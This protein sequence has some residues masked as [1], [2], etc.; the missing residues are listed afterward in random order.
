MSEMQYQVMLAKMMAVVDVAEKV[1]NLWEL[2]P[3]TRIPDFIR[4]ALITSVR[5][6]RVVRSQEVKR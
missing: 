2:Y 3:E 1:S 6:L 5:E 4:N